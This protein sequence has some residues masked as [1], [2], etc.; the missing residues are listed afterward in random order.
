MFLEI[1][2]TITRI[3]I[4]FLPSI[5]ATVS[6]FMLRNYVANNFYGDED[7]S[8]E[9]KDRVHAVFD[10]HHA[11]GLKTLSLKKLKP[12]YTEIFLIQG[13]PM[14]SEGTTIV[15]NEEFIASLPDDEFEALI[16]QAAAYHTHSIM[17]TWLLTSW[18]I[19]MSCGIAG[20]ML[21]QYLHNCTFLPAFLCTS[22]QFLLRWNILAVLIGP[23][24]SSWY[25]AYD[26]TRFSFTL[27]QQ[28][29]HIPGYIKLYTRLYEY[30][31]L[32]IF[33]QKLTYF[34]KHE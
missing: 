30:T 6:F 34:K 3:V 15:F 10:K 5:S 23:A 4:L 2:S 32:P 31:K 1:L 29:G 12:E 13:K 18:F 24:I 17:R 20:Y 9:L 14:F 25:F 27:A 22:V 11:S 8:Q 19:Q 33:L 21:L 7:L 28:S 26:N 16:L